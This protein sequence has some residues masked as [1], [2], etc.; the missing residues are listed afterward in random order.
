MRFKGLPRPELDDAWEGLLQ[1]MN[2]RVSGE[3]AERTNYTSIELT[4]GSG[5]LFAM[6]AVFHSLHCLKSIRQYLFPES[7]PDAWE[8]MKPAELGGI[9]KHMDHC[10][11]NLRQSLLC[12]GDMSPYR[13]EWQPTNDMP[14][15]FARMEHICVE[16]DKVMD[17][18]EQRSF[19]I[20]DG[21]L[22]NPYTGNSPKTF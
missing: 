3:E 10:I 17:W 18:A 22:Q 11:E 4:D 19:S 5:D 7:Y 2:I 13:Y 21:L 1:Y 15:P 6:P 12:Q 14:K 20:E 16:W 9:S 8:Y